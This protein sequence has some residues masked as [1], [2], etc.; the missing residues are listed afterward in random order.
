MATETFHQNCTQVLATA[1]LCLEKKLQMPA[2]ILIY[3]LIDTFAWVVSDNNEK[4]TRK[5]FE[6]WVE[7]W[8]L[9]HRPLPCSATEL[10]AARCAVLHTLS[11][12]TALTQSGE[13]RQVAHAW[14]STDVARLQ[15]SINALGRKDVVALGIEELF[16]AVGAA[17]RLVME[18]SQTDAVL[19]ERLEKASATVFS[20]AERLSNGD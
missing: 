10:Y 6:N 8:M 18:A 7:K 3:T 2:L 12:Q 20:G 11:S 16:E 4:S 9:A 17:M 1:R 19:R 14:A 13:A 15:E 5:R